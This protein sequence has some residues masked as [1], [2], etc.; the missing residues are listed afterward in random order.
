VDIH[1]EITQFALLL[2]NNEEYL[3]HKHQVLNPY[4][5]FFN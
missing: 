3:F 5:H 1:I 4:A 2:N